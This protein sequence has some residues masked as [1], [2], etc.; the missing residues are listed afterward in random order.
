[1]KK[2]TLLMALSL[3]CFGLVSEANA[4]DLSLAPANSNTQTQES[5]GSGMDLHRNAISVELLGRGGL[6][7]LNYDYLL[8]DDLAVGAGV[9]TYSIS[10]G[11]SS[12]SAWVIPVYANYY[13]TGQHHRLFVTGGANMIMAS[14]NLNGDN[15]ISG[16]GLAGVFGGGYEYRGDSG[17][18]FR[19]APYLMVG[20]ESGAWFGVSLGYAI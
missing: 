10:S 3:L 16:S 14:G 12:A 5:V 15:Q 18:L 8:R 17:F 7:S 20:K 9:S 13:L 6:Y 1:M 4:A 19:A 2:S 11:G